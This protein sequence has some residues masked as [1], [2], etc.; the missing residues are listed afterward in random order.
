M[1][2]T[3]P[4]TLF[5]GKEVL[6][7]PSCHSTNDTALALIASSEAKDGMVV[8]THEQLAGRGQQGNGW[9]AE[10]NKNLTLSVILNPVW[11]PI[12]Q[13][14]YL[15]MA[16]ALAIRDT[17]RHYISEPIYIKWPNDIYVN[18][19]KISGVLIQNT[20]QASHIKH[21]VVGIGINVNQK[22][23]QNLQATSISKINK[24]EIQLEDLF[25]VL[26]EYLEKRYLSIKKSEFKSL[27]NEYETA[28]FRKQMFANYIINEQMIIG[29]IIGV[30]DSGL[31][32]MEIEN[33]MKLYDLKKVKYVF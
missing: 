16:V 4:K 19:H 33:E 20:I 26:L 1:Y 27:K 5:I 29:K 15:S 10:P 11:L 25:C 18:D 22:I 17:L 2:K 6:V 30:E 14:F 9:E 13:Q 8:I 3:V 24:K 7:L 12:Y 28:L 32:K 23:F 21:S 31:L